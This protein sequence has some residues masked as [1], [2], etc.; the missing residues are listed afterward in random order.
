MSKIL[1]KIDKCIYCGAV[2]GLTDE[3]IIP[4]SLNGDYVLQQ[5]SCLA[6]CDITSRFEQEVTRNFLRPMRAYFGLKTRRVHPSSFSISG[7][8]FQF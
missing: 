6:C 7:K 8:I 1:G 4:Y 3:H 5:A 2:E